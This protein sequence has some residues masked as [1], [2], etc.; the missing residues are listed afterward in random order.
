VAASLLVPPNVLAASDLATL[1]KGNRTQRRKGHKG[2][3]GR[4]SPKVAKVEAQKQGI[5]GYSMAFTDHYAGQS[6]SRLAAFKHRLAI[7]EHTIDS[8]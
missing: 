3:K 2:R 4:K 5:A 6:S 1:R 7:H 8:F